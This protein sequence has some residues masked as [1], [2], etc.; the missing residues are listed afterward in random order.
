MASK[1]DGRNA[2]VTNLRSLLKEEE[3]RHQLSF[4]ELR[5]EKESM[6]QTQ[7]IAIEDLRTSHQREKTDLQS[8]I[9]SL[10][11]RME[12]EKCV[13]FT[14]IIAISNILTRQHHFSRKHF[15]DHTKRISELRNQEVARFTE[16]VQ[17]LTDENERHQQT[18]L[19]Y[20]KTCSN[21]SIKI[22]ETE[23][24][25]GELQ[26]THAAKVK[27]FSKTMKTKNLIIADLE[28]TASQ[29]NEALKMKETQHSEQAHTQNEELAELKSVSLLF[30]H[31]YFVYEFP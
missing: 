1:L 5:N 31:R 15:E 2:E 24:E 28:N 21:Q 14:N 7:A 13:D 19:D 8:R 29:L 11:T 22:R 26:K 10:T 9:H 20:E 16:Q 23:K 30:F 18:I 27:E 25:L 6:L 12:Q 3:T 4:E 17:R